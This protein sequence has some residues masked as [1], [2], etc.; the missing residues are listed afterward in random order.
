MPVPAGTGTGFPRGQIPSWP[1]RRWRTVVCLSQRGQAHA[2]AD[3]MKSCRC[4]SPCGDRHPRNLWV[5][6]PLRGQIPSWRSSVDGV[7]QC[8]C[9]RGDRHTHG[10]AAVLMRD[11]HRGA[12]PR[13]PRQG[14][15]AGRPKQHPTVA[16][17]ANRRAE[18]LLW[19]PV[20]AGTDTVLAVKRSWR[21]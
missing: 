17:Y 8:A 21:N 20:P 11:R 3:A 16:K 2:R 6:V 5:P 13:H 15:G 19:V 10:Q 14:I 12:R 4:Q 7:R 1:S 18:P 9:P